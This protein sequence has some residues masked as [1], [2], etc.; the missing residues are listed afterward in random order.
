MSAAD[1]EYI[2]FTCATYCLFDIAA[3]IDRIASDPLEW[4]GRG[5]GARDHSRRKL[6]FGRKADIGG[7]VGGFEASWIVSPFLRKIQHAIDERMTVARHIGSEDATLAV[8]DLACGT[9]PIPATEDRLL[10]PQTSWELV[11][12]SGV[13]IEAIS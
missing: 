3:D 11:D 4:D 8:L 12:R 9:S 5:Y 10:P 1:P 13:A 7:H 2:V 6:W